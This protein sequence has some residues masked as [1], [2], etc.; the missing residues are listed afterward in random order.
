MR[1]DYHD[2]NDVASNELIESR[3]M[4]NLQLYT[5]IQYFGDDILIVIYIFI[6]LYIIMIVMKD[7]VYADAAM[8]WLGTK[9]LSQLCSNTVRILMTAVQASS[10]A[11][12][13]PSSIR[14]CDSVFKMTPSHAKISKE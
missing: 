10:D 7:I 5:T 8:T 12:R 6:V 11:D 1:A 4:I 3:K 2:G 14:V 13:H 9:H